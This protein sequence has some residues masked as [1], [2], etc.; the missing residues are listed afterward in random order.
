[1]G[2]NLVY[3]RC[4]QLFAQQVGAAVKAYGAGVCVLGIEGLTGHSKW[5]GR[6]VRVRSDTERSIVTL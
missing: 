1:M 2:S 5:G 3:G 6:T 4:G